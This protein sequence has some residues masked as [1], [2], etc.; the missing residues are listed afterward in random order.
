MAYMYLLKEVSQAEK[1]LNN[2]EFRN[3][4]KLFKTFLKKSDGWNAKALACADSSWREVQEKKVKVEQS[5][6][7]I[8]GRLDK[9]VANEQAAPQ[10]AAKYQK[11]EIKSKAS[12]EKALEVE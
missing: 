1:L 12:M 8:H 5:L 9:A 6:A 10:A 2:P 3:S 11:E 4:Y 7:Q